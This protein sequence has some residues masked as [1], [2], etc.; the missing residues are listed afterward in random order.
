MTLA[1]DFLI[2]SL[3]FSAI[4]IF[5]FLAASLGT[6]DLISARLAL[7]EVFT[8]AVIGLNCLEDCVPVVTPVAILVW[9]VAKLRAE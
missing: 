3:L 6:I 2:S 1:N 8:E 9:P 7:G 5:L 4:Y